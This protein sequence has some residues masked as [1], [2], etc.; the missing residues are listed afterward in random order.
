MKT[1]P[2]AKYDGVTKEWLLRK[3]LMDKLFQSVG[4]LCIDKGIKVVEIPDFVYDL[5]KN[6]IP[7]SGKAHTTAKDVKAIMTHCKEFNYEHESKYAKYSLEKSL[8]QKTFDN[9]Y[10]F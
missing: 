4:E 7:F 9:L 8:P 2:D 5:S 6:S 3:D 10:E 1:L